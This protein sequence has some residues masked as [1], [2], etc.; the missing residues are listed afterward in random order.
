MPQP[1]VRPNV[2][3]LLT[4]VDSP[5]RD[6]WSLLY[7][8]DGTVL[9]AAEHDLFCTATP[10]EMTAAK[11]QRRLEDEWARETHEM[12]VTL[13]DLFTKYVD[14]LPDGSLGSDAIDL[15]TDEDYAEY[16]RLIKIVA[17]RNGLEYRTEH[18]DS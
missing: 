11:A 18:E 10:A 13:V 17:A 2:V 15:M 1:S 7:R 9:T 16:E 6:D 12:N 8:H 4:E 3:V 5:R 14:Q